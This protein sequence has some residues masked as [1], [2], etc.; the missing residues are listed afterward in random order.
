MK[1]KQYQKAID[2]FTSCVKIEPIGKAYYMRGAAYNYLNN[3]EN[4]CKD[5]RKAASLGHR[6]AKRDMPRICK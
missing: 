1:S 6:Q 5:T 3:T 4:A 2:A